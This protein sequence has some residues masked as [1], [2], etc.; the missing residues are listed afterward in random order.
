MLINVKSKHFEEYKSSQKFDVNLI[1]SQRDKLIKEKEYLRNSKFERNSKT[2]N[3]SYVMTN[4]FQPKIVK[5]DKT[6]SDET[7]LKDLPEKLLPIDEIEENENSIV[8]EKIPD[9]LKVTN[10]HPKNFLLIWINF[11]FFLYLKYEFFY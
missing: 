8:S 7:Y 1:K 11:C 5:L 10:Y 6:S 2:I 4:R 3:H 9:I